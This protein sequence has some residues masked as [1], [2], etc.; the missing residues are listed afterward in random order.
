MTVYDSCIY[1]QE[2]VS[3][4][5]FSLTFWK[6][7]VTSNNNLKIPQRLPNEQEFC[8]KTHLKDMCAQIEECKFSNEAELNA[9]YHQVKMVY[10]SFS[11]AK[12]VCTDVKLS[13]RE[14]AI[15]DKGCNQVHTFNSFLN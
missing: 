5:F 12:K 10:L 6:E 15:F 3:S 4:S 14:N 8:I 11:N 13:N 2:F 1:P 7:F 9:L